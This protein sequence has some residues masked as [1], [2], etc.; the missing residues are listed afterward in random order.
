MNP[1]LTTKVLN[2]VQ[3]ASVLSKRA[4]DELGKKQAAEKSAASK[5]NE[6]T[7]YMLRSGVIDAN[8]KQAAEQ[9]LGSHEQT[10]SLLKNAVQKIAEFKQGNIK[11]ASELGQP[12]GE[13]TGTS[14]RD[15]PEWSLKDPYVGARSSEKKASDVAMLRGLGLA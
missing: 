9:M 1:Q 13:A 6:L 2:F 15:N 7:E 5:V 10:M 4:L 3:V 12:V 8:Q 14:T 11:K